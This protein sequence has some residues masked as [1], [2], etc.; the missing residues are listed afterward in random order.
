M[1][2]YVIV[3]RSFIN[4]HRFLDQNKIKKLP[5]KSFAELPNLHRLEVKSDCF[6][7]IIAWSCRNE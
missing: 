2:S 6:T 5:S 1:R 3:W 4:N 7:S